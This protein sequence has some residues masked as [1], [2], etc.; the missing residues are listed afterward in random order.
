MQD[1]VQVTGEKAT[2]KTKVLPCWSFVSGG[3]VGGT[4]NSQ[5][6]IEFKG[7]LNE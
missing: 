1:P 6:K 2:N 7:K 4:G 5:V 3:R